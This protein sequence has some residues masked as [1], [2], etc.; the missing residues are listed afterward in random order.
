V[1]R[2]AAIALVLTAAAAAAA[3]FSSQ[4]SFRDG[5]SRLPGVGFFGVSEKPPNSFRVDAIFDT[6]K[7]VIPGQLVKVAGVRVGIVKD[8][9]LTPD[10]KARFEMEVDGRFA[11]FRAD[12][13]C[14]IQPE[15]LTAEN[16]VQCNP[17]TPAASVLRSRGGGTPTVP[18]ARTSTPV[19]LSALFDIWSLPARERL[20]VLINEL[21]LS[22]A[23]RGDDLNEVL[24]R[25][26]PSLVLAQ[27]AIRILNRQRGQLASIVDST[28]RIV[29]E[30]A[31][32]RGRVRDFIT[33]AAR[34][35]GQTAQHRDA[36]AESV[37]RMPA[38]LDASQPALRRAD[39]FAVAGTP[40]LQQLHASAP[41]LNRAVADLGP[42]AAASIP[43]LRGL[44]RTVKK[45]LAVARRARPLAAA[46]RRF[47]P[48]AKPISKR[49]N[50]QF[51][52]LRDSGFIEGGL[53][54]FYYLAAG[55]A[56]FDSTSHIL[57]AH[58]VLNDC[59]TFATAPV[60]GCSAH[61][62]SLSTSSRRSRGRTSRRSRAG[63]SPVP[64]S[65]PPRAPPRAAAPPAR[66]PGRGLLPLAPLRDVLP[67]PGRSHDRRMD[68]LLRY[69]L[70]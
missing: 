59:G 66:R 37:R 11:P 61:Y 67:E 2:L 5:V 41:S 70:G 9:K 22:L 30:L 54:L 33:E 63:S 28:D 12:A 16:F 19:N 51:S 58:L 29:A 23:G 53:S 7:G 49:I 35:T 36:L 56:R 25:T 18:V 1:R 45:G 47:T 48:I 13:A 21:G 40:L 17:G 46:Q 50:Q 69:L 14:E 39:E 32:R 60:P 42:F 31:R 27:R 44:R 10:Y 26:N 15:G 3:L 38:L 55:S 57:P 43:P 64:L 62:G 65:A 68:L 34:V 52:S 24:R 6:A 8:V 20:R 4:S